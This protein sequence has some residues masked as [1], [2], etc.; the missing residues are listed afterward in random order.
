QMN[1]AKAINFIEDVSYV[2]GMLFYSFMLYCMIFRTKNDLGKY[3]YLQRIITAEGV[4]AMVPTS[5]YHI[6]AELLSAYLALY[7][8]TFVMVDYS[9]LYRLWAVRSFSSIYFLYL[10]TESGRRRMREAALTEYRI[11]MAKHVMIMGDYYQAVIPLV[12]LYAPCG[13]VNILPMFHL[14]PYFF[15]RATP[16]IVSCF[17][18]LDTLA[19]L[20]SMGDYRREVL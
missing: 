17:L 4:Y 3:R 12:T 6:N 18:P 16:P 11:D 19:V 8:L 9:F 1:Y 2:I 15:A 5:V 20:L 10:P 7:T 13:F 14:D